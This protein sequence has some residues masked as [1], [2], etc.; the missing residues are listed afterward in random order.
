MKINDILKLPVVKI[1]A[2]IF[3]LY[4]LFDKTKDD[5]RSISYHLKSANIKESIKT[6]K[7][8]QIDTENSTNSNTNI[9]QNNSP[10]VSYE[11]L[12]VS[13]EGNPVS[14]GNEV[15]IEYILFDRDTNDFFNKSQM[16][17]IIGEKFNRLI[18]KGI[19]NMKKRG[20]RIINIPK[21]FSTGDRKY[22][23]LITSRN[24]AYKVTLHQVSS[25]IKKELVCE[26]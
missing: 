7:N 13:S 21:N 12:I 25:E 10:P 5:P 19:I 8:S 14:C 24:M 23:N 26:Q 15:S 20:V 17:F 1:G 16:T 22:D 3:L 9:D 11:D 18:E 2:M 6:I 4:Y